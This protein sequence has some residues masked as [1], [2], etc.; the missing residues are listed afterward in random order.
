MAEFEPFSFETSDTSE[1]LPINWD[2]IK[3]KPPGDN[4]N[5]ET[6]EQLAER[7]AKAE[8]TRRFLNGEYGSGND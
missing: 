5:L 1:A 3:V 4:V 7:A 8:R 6:E 2:E